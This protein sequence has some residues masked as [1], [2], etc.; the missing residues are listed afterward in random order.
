MKNGRQLQ[1]LVP[2][3][4][5]QSDVSLVEGMKV[6]MPVYHVLGKI[7]VVRSLSNKIV[8]MEKCQN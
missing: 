5:W 7:P 8:V 4:T 2:A 6:L 3:F 1:Q